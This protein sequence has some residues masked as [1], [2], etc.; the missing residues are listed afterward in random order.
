[1]QKDLMDEIE[2][3]VALEQETDTPQ[4]SPQ[5]EDSQQETQVESKQDRNWREM[6]RMNSELE[7]KANAQ[8][9]LITTLLKTQMSNQNAPPPE[10]E[11]DSVSDDDYIPKRDVKKLLKK[12][13]ENIRREVREEAKKVLEDQERANFHRR[14]KDKFADFDEIV[15][16]ETLELLDEQDPE[17]ANTIAEL[18]DPYKIGLQTYKYVKSMGLASKAPAQK[19]MKEVDKKLEQNAKTVQSPLA[20]DKRPMA[21]TFKMTEQMK[22]DLWKEM[23]GYASLA[24]GVPNL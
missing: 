16:P 3:N 19:R 23:N 17:L 7:K 11:L 14:L 22:Q 5:E 2:N 9:A 13:T 15:T 24:D 12:E 21:Q 8:E 10:D 20:Y 1:M 6:R 4:I 18:K